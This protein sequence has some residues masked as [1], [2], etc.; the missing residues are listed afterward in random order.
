MKPTVVL[1]LATVALVGATGT[2][3]AASG[4]AGGAV[5]ADENPDGQSGVPPWPGDETTAGNDTA[6]DGSGGGDA[7]SDP[8]ERG[9]TEGDSADGADAGRDSSDS[10]SSD[11]DSA[12]GDTTERETTSVSPGQQLAGA[13][14]AQGAS[15]QGELWNRTLSAR[16]ANATTAD[17]RAEVIADEVETIETYVGDLEAVRKNLTGAWEAGELSEG[18]YRASLSSFVV[19]AYSVEHRA[20]RTARAAERLPDGVAERHGIEVAHV[21]NLSE[22]AHDLY[23]FEDPIAQEV[24]NETLS[25]QS[26]LA[27]V[28]PEGERANST[29]SGQ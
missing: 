6:D 28:L 13:V 9:A 27:G 16:L 21:R 29:R 3:G 22:R 14:G 4:H 2:V 15:V 18:E 7:D 5:W 8:S 25:N 10:D 12:D 20:N 17:E 26:A 19:R 24:A 1:L 23:Q 11:G